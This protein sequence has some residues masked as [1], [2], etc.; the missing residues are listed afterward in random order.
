[1]SDFDEAADMA[2]YDNMRAELEAE[3]RLEP[4][5]SQVAEEHTIAQPQHQEQRQDYEPQ[6][7]HREFPTCSKT[8]SATSTAGPARL[9]H[10]CIP[11]AIFDAIQQDEK[12]A[13]A[14]MSDYWDA[15]AHLEN[16][17]ERE[18]QRLIPD[19]QQGDMYAHRHGLR[20][21][22]EARAAHLSMDRQHVV[23]WAMQNGVSPAQA[24]YRLA[25]QKG[26]RPTTVPRTLHQQVRQAKGQ[27]FDKAWDVYSKVSRAA[28]ENYKARR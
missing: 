16:A 20:N 8:R 4:R 11:A 19:G 27:D 9:K 3:G 6:H 5:E 22:A 1:M 12:A 28:D 10:I 26:Y 2:K 7:T 17:R 24:Y 25:Q 15:C 23:A 13:E 21:A 14:E 18:L